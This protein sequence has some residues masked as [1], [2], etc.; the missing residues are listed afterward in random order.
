MLR[1]GPHRKI[2]SP[3]SHEPGLFNGAGVRLAYIMPPMPPMPPM[4][5]MPPASWGFARS[6]SNHGFGGDHQTA[7]RSS[8]L[9]GRT[10]DLGWVQDAHFDHV[11]VFA[12]SSVVTEVTRTLLDLVGNNAWLVAARWQ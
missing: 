11:A 4:S 8:S 5:G 12:G 9:Q 2:K 10:G 3:G 7:N 1:R 6:V